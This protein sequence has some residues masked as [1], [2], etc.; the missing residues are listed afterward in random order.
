MCGFDDRQYRGAPACLVK[1]RAEIDPSAVD[2]RIIATKDCLHSGKFRIVMESAA[3][4][5]KPVPVEQDI[6]VDERD[7]FAVAMAEGLVVPSCKTAVRLAAID[8]KT[9]PERN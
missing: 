2:R 3:N 5:R 7:E 8:M 9:M 1:S 6:V 4:R